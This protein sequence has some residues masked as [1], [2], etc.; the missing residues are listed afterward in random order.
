MTRR[1]EPLGKLCLFF[2]DFSKLVMVR[3]PRKFQRL[4]AVTAISFSDWGLGSDSG[5]V[6]GLLSGASV[7]DLC[8][9]L[10]VRDTPPLRVLPEFFFHLMISFRI[11][12]TSRC[13]AVDKNFVATAALL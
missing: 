13:C 6:E 11:V 10:H 12:H 5:W 4:C 7:T 3:L 8:V 1:D 2:A 9:C